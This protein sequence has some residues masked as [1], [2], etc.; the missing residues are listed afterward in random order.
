MPFGK[1]NCSAIV[2]VPI[3]TSPQLTVAAPHALA[4]HLR[5]ELVRFKDVAPLLKNVR[6]DS[7]QPEHWRSLFHKLGIDKIALPQLCLNASNTHASDKIH[8]GEQV[9]SDNPAVQGRRLGGREPSGGSEIGGEGRPGG[10]E[11]ISRE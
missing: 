6:G 4:D 7:F 1:H 11:K 2:V 8:H 3:L 9:T 5:A 10:G